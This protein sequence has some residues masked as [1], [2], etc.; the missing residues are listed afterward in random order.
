[1]YA[2]GVSVNVESKDG[3]DTSGIKTTVDEAESVVK[4]EVG[5]GVASGTTFEIVIS[6]A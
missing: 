4:V 3:S 6:P 1:M 2:D 5:D